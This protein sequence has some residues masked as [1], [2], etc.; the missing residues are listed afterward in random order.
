MNPLLSIKGLG[1]RFGQHQAVNGLDLILERGKMLALVG[2]SGC[3]KSVTALSILGLLPDSARLS[4]A[5][6][7]AGQDLLSLT[8]RQLRA[9]RGNDISMVFQE[10]MT[11][12]NPLHTVGEQI[13]ESLRQ[14]LGLSPRLARA[15]AIELLDRVQLPHPSQRVDYYPHQLSGGQRQRVMIAMAVA[16]EP[17]L[18]IADE[19]TTALDVTVQGKIMALIDD[20]RRSMSMSVLMISHD[21]GL[22]S[23]WADDVA[24]MHGGRKLEH[25]ASAELF[26][27]PQ[28]DYTRGLMAASLHY[29]P[30]LHYRQRCLTEI[31]AGKAADEPPFTLYTPP[32]LSFPSPLAVAS[33]PPVLATRGLNVSYTQGSQRVKAVSEVSFELFK[34]ETLGLVGESGCGKSTLSR[35]ILQLV[36]ADSGQILL[37]GS[38]ILGLKGSQLGALRSRVQMIFQDPFASLNPRQTVRGILDRV[39]KVNGVKDKKTR[40]QRIATM[41][42][43][44]GLPQHSLDRFAH[45][46]SGG[47]RQRIGIARAL[48]TRPELVICDEAVSALDVSI[49]A[50]VLNLLLE[51]KSEFGLSYLFISHNLDVVRYM[52]DRVLV[53]QRGKIVESGEVARVWQSPQH[54]YTQELLSALGAEHF[55]Q[56]AQPREIA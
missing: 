17:K 10:P 43:R 41:I 53:M 46:F 40:Q 11:S 15:R 44:V 20:L 29:Q 22:M 18:L 51:L 30:N 45:E 23:Q 21:L 47:Q 3:G 12:L 35:A 2:E 38:D 39:L 19:P 56:H 7:F 28:H 42:D 14:H 4:G 16:C 6:D 37:H 36:K 8:P 52:A 25:N 32:T 54:A 48:I 55:T 9:L 34:G 13:S 31:R 5:I 1:V 49:Q 24:V 26:A 27:D 33:S 50:Q